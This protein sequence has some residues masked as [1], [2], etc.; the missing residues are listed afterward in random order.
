[1]LVRAGKEVGELTPGPWQGGQELLSFSS[2]HSTHGQGICGKG[3]AQA[4]FPEG[5]SA[6]GCVVWTGLEADFQEHPQLGLKLGGG[7]LK[8]SANQL[9]GAFK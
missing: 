5:A 6:S 8:S 9:K 7:E 1:M 3:L 2:C 4:A